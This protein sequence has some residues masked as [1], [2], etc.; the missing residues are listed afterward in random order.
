M[1]DHTPINARLAALLPRLETLQSVEQAQGHHFRQ[2]RDRDDE[3]LG[4]GVTKAERAGLSMRVDEYR[5]PLGDGWCLVVERLVG[6]ER[7]VRVVH[8]GP[9]AWREQAWSEK[10][11]RMAPA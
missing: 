2:I 7:F 4:A 10:P 6:A 3:W 5:G 9:E 1:P 8:R 11:R